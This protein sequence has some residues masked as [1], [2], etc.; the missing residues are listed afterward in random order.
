MTT[1]VFL[2]G[3]ELSFD[4]F[5]T[6]EQLQISRCEEIK[7]RIFFNSLP[8]GGITR[9]EV[10]Q[11][12]TRFGGI[13]SVKLTPKRQGLTVRVTF[14]TRASCIRCLREGELWLGSHKA[15]A[16]VQ[17]DV[18][19]QFSSNRGRLS[20]QASIPSERT[21]LVP[22]FPLSQQISQNKISPAKLSLNQFPQVLREG[23]SQRSLQKSRLNSHLST[24]QL[25]SLESMSRLRVGR[26]VRSIQVVGQERQT[27]PQ[28]HVVQSQELQEQSKSEK[29][30]FGFRAL[31]KFTIRKVLKQY[32]GKL[33]SDRD[34]NKEIRF[35]IRMK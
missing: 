26:S 12:L 17:R 19:S 4:R 35:N 7:R 23:G 5:K 11:S 24:L 30:W 15:V 29:D 14:E 9:E 10:I 34:S 20:F 32:N 27:A 2:K 3:K 16:E 13:L 22:C 1:P 33:V 18:S 6:E 8:E 21:V 25:F 31:P 28:V